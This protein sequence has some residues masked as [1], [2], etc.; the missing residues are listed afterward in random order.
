MKRRI[1]NIALM[2]SVI[3]SMIA[4]AFTAIPARAAED[5]FSLADMDAD[6]LAN[7]LETAGWYN[8]S[9][10]PFKTDPRRSG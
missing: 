6:G 5:P 1:F 8:L 7:D 4:P 3:F 9:G 10:G 2:L